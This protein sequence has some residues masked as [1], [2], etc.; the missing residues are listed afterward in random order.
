[1]KIT[2]LE[3]AL[4]QINIAIY[5]YFNELDLISVHT[6]AWASRTIMFDLCKYKRIK[7]TSLSIMN[8]NYRESYE[9]FIRKAQNFFKHA[10]EKDDYKKDFDFK[11]DMTESILYDAISFYILYTWNQ[12]NHMK[13]YNSYYYLKNSKNIEDTKIRQI[14][15]KQLQSIKKLPNKKDF[16][17]QIKS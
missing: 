17:E 9:I 6:L 11:E 7:T 15:E 3:A 8:K 4:K 12:S 10:A 16:Y 13:I 1:M 14:V 5:L 2:K